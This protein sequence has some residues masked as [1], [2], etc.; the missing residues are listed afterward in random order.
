[1]ANFTT[2]G[3]I[4]IERELPVAN[5]QHY[6]DIISRFDINETCQW[7]RDNNYGKVCLQFPDEL[8]N[9]SAKIYEEIKKQIDVDLY[10]LGDTSYAS[11]C[12]DSVAAMHVES[13]AVIHYGHTCFS[14][15]NI[16]VYTVL[17]KR[18]LNV[19]GCMKIVASNYKIDDNV[20]LCLFYDEEF[21]HCKDDLVHHWFRLYSKSY[22]ASVEMEDKPERFLGR[23]IR[24]KQGTIYPPDILKDCICIYIGSRG[25][26]LFNYTISIAAAEW[27]LLDP[28]SDRL[29]HVEETMWFKRRRYLVE[30]CKDANVVGILVCKLAGDQTKD[31]ISR[32]KHLCKVN[33]KKSYIVSVGKPNVA[34]LANFPEIDIYVLIACPENDLYSNRDF[35]KPIVYPYELEVALNSNREPYFTHHVTDYDDLLPGKRHYCDID[36]VKELTDV[37]LITG[38][39]RETRI[40][41]NE[42]GSQEL[43][44]K[45]NWALES[46]GSNLQDRSWKGL[47]QK[48]G[49]TEVKKAE[50]GRKGIPLQYSNEPE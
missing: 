43:A 14:K 19:Q 25:Q 49:E 13:E 38:R 10:I 1:M 27:H 12:V 50:V 22:I 4:C 3:K 46:I 11:C 29:E 34:K 31:I 35:Y 41:N 5:E 6:D 36:H 47:E 44:E 48:L 37:S 33:G 42:S 15:T 18:E 16:P 9:V 26:T 8:L 20:K 30:K 40:E 21:E 17:P 45:Q 7:I 23:T 28:E 2:D 39:I 32:M 24:D